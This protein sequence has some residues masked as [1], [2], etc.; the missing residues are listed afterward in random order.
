MHGSQPPTLPQIML[1]PAPNDTTAVRARAIHHPPSSTLLHALL[2]ASRHGSQDVKLPSRGRRWLAASPAVTPQASHPTAIALRDWDAVGRESGRPSPP[3][4]LSACTPPLLHP[5]PTAHPP[6][7]T[8][9]PLRR[10]QSL[11]AGSV[12]PSRP[13]SRIR[14]RQPSFFFYYYGAV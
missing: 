3:V 14:A 12:A 7:A 11:R 9:E 4:R 8:R 2:P 6:R 5:P 13:P 10:L 1:M